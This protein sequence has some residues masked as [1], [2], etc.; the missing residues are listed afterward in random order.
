MK[1]QSPEEEEEETQT[2][3]FCCLSH[4]FFRV[5]SANPNKTAVIHASG[6]AH[7]STRLRQTRV[8]SLSPPV[9]NGDRCF[10]YSHLLKAIDFPASR[11]SSIL[12]GADDPHLITPKPQGSD[13]VVNHEKG[14]IYAAKNLETNVS[15]SESWEYIC[16]LVEYIVAVFSVLRCGEAFLPLDPYWPKERLLSIV[17]SSSADLIIGSKSS[18]G[19]E[20]DQLDQSHWL[21]KSVSC[22]V[23]SFSI[24]ERLQEYSDLTDLLWPCANEKKSSFYY[25]MYTSGSTGKP[26]G[27]CGTEQAHGG[28]VELVVLLRD[29]YPCL[30]QRR[31]KRKQPLQNLE[32]EVLKVLVCSRKGSVYSFKPE[33]GDLLWEH[34]VGDPITSSAYVDEHLQLVSDDASHSS[35][36]LICICSS[37][38]RIH[39]LR[40][41]L[42]SSDDTI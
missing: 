6:V 41:N 19:S 9:Y 34:N 38:G 28:L 31:E 33:N 7:L 27:V 25:L 2:P 16:H 4:E 3:R 30:E 13:N 12:L 5:A 42:N 18:F 29:L 39:L 35:D 22:P 26:K 37:S 20:L 17:A 21:V 32:K 8:E 10:T 24:E 14:T 40:E 36:M 15:S 1:A 23:L 11:I